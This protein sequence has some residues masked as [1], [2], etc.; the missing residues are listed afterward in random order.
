MSCISKT[1]FKKSDLLVHSKAKDYI[2]EFCGKAF[3]DTTK[4]QVI[5]IIL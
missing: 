4:L 5:T 3:R 2:C 1:N